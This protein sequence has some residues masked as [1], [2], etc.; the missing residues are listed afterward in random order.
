MKIRTGFVTNSSSTN[1][2]IISKEELT[3]E[4]LLHQLG[5]RKGSSL[6]FLGKKLVDDLMQD[7]LCCSK[8]SLD[9]SQ[10][11]EIKDSFGDQSVKILE[12][13]LKKGYSV[14][15]GHTSTDNGD[16]NLAVL[17]TVDSFEIHKEDFYLNAKN[18]VW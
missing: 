8:H 12:K 16:S 2:L 1:F 11:A 18:C 5:F 9:E 6:E 14:Y 15:I 4:K 7:M 3:K 13:L 17:F 10:I